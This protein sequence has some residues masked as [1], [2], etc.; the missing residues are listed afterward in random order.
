[1]FGWSRFAKSV[2]SCQ[3][4]PIILRPCSW[5]AFSMKVLIHDQKFIWIIILPPSPFPFNYLYPLSPAPPLSSSSPF[6]T[7]FR[8]FVA[9]FIV[10]PNPLSLS[11]SSPS[12]YKCFL[13]FA[14]G[15]A[16]C[17]KDSLSDNRVSVKHKVYLLTNKF[18]SNNQRTL[19]FKSNL[20]WRVSKITGSSSWRKQRWF[21]F[22]PSKTFFI[23]V[24]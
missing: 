24:F 22:Y 15:R 20:I 23:T 12:F 4:E 8:F 18:Y 21:I 1:M 11:S 17:D 6:N 16:C 14:F 9:L 7:G 13:L 19:L 5:I 10:R 2:Y 3:L